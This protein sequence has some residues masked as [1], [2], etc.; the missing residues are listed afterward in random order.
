MEWKILQTIFV[1]IIVGIWSFY[2]IKEKEIPILSIVAGGGLLLV[3][4]VLAGSFSVHASIGGILL[5]AILYAISKL[6]KEAMGVGD[7]M[8]FGV[9][10]IVLGGMEALVLLFYSLVMAGIFS[11]IMLLLHKV[12]KKQAIPFLPFVWMSYLGVCLL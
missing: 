10:G 2:D 1:G 8:V 3:M 9:L 11:V 5:G 4:A 12:S 7:V 6:T